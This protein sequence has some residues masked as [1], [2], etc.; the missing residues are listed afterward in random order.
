MDEIWAFAVKEK[1]EIKPTGS[2]V[3]FF[4]ALHVLTSRAH[5]FGSLL[6]P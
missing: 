6:D 2:S 1:G 3:W 4:A 5:I